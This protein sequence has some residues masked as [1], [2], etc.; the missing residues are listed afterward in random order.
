MA[1]EVKL[2][3]FITNMHR[4]PNFMASQTD[5]TMGTGDVG[6]ILLKGVNLTMHNVKTQLTLTLV[7]IANTVS[8]LKRGNFSNEVKGMVCSNMIK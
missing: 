5:S 6:L 3:D 4:A 8:K 7:N 2:L 1:T